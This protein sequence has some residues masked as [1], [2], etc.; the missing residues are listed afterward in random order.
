MGQIMLFSRGLTV[1]KY[2]VYYMVELF[3]YKHNLIRFVRRGQR[4][5]YLS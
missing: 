5:T 3:I 2:V 1:K 4:K